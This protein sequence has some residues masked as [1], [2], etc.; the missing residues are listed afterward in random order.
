MPDLLRRSRIP[1]DIESVTARGVE[2][3]PAAV[4][5]TP[6]GV[7]RIWDGV[8]GVYRGGVHPAIQ[9]CVRRQGRIVLDRAIGH[10]RGNGPQDGPDTDKD[11][12]T[13]ETPFCVFSASKAITATV[14]HMLDE[15]GLLH[16]DDRVCE[17]IPEF[18]RHGKDAITLGQVL[19]HRAGIPNHPRE[20]LDLDQLGNRELLLRFLCDAKPF[21]KPGRFVA[22]HALSGG[23]ILGEVV[24][25]VTGKSIREVLAA[26]ILDPL[27][28]RWTNYGVADEDVSA[29]ATN[30]VTGLPALP[31]VSTMLTRLLGT[32]VA[33]AV[34]LTNDPRFLTAV[35][36]AG[37]VVTTA[38][39][40]SRFFE[41]L[42]CGGA[43]DGVRILEPRTIRRA[44]TQQNHLEVDFTLGV[45]IGYSMGFML[46]GR[47]I[48][49]FGPDTEQVFGHLG[50]TNILSWADPARGLS[51]GLITSGK[52]VVYPEI[53][54]FLGIMGRIGAAAPK[55]D[56]SDLGEF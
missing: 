7:E 10:A 36:P 42:R 6:E 34:E 31:P 2:E 27:S 28:F 1:K 54:G 49:L 47:R 38:A 14:V 18:A 29:V 37:N 53:L 56:S 12:V 41:L 9:V 39:E 33:E 13:T 48:S 17:Y 51:V 50:F 4:G 21:F 8:V 43:L 44:I 46:G 15:R 52:P 3:D 25:R 22:Y 40:L 30:Y 20:V 24:E 19:A 32:P 11:D 55:V 16:V 45:P 23:A 5:M 26:E 35:V